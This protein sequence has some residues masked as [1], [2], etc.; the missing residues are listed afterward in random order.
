MVYNLYHIW[1]I[2]YFGPKIGTAP[3]VVR[4]PIKNL[5]K[6]SSLFVNQ[7]LQNKQAKSINYKIKKLKENIRFKSSV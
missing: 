7:V 1:A 6:E 3:F 4:D 5:V 2:L